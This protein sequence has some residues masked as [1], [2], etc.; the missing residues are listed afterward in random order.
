MRNLVK[1]LDVLTP[2]PKLLKALWLTA[3][4]GGWRAASLGVG[5]FFFCLFSS[6][7]LFFFP[8]QYSLVLIF[9]VAPNP[10]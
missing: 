6:L 3:G 10:S 5:L 2:Q 9:L 4:V 8:F 1:V 7:S